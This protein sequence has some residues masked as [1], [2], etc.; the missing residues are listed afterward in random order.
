[1]P[2]QSKKR[3]TFENPPLPELPDF[4]TSASQLPDFLTGASKMK[5]LPHLPQLAHEEVEELEV[6]VAELG[7]EHVADMR[8]ID[9][10]Y[11]KFWERKLGSMRK[12]VEGDE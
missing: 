3:V 10:E 6:A 2:E 1:M 9:R 4:F 8:A 11:Q 7:D 12:A 5:T